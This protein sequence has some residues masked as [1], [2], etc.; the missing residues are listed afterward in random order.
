MASALKTVFEVLLEEPFLFIEKNGTRFI[1]SRDVDLFLLD[2]SCYALKIAKDHGCVIPEN[3]NVEGL[4]VRNPSAD[5]FKN[6]VIASII[7]YSRSLHFMNEEY[8]SALLRKRFW[9]D[10]TRPVCYKDGSWGMVETKAT[11]TY[12]ALSWPCFSIKLEKDSFEKWFDLLLVNDFDLVCLSNQS[13]RTKFARLPSIKESGIDVNLLIQASSELKKLKA[14][15]SHSERLK[16]ET[17]GLYK[18]IKDDALID[19]L[20]DCDKIRAD[21]DSYDVKMITDPNRGHWELWENSDNQINFVSRNPLKDI[22]ENGVVGIDFGTKSTIVVYQNDNECII[23]MRVGTGELKKAVSKEDFENP[24]VMELISLDSFMQ[25][26]ENGWRPKTKWQDLKV[27]R[28]ADKDYFNCSLKNGEYSAFFSDIKQWAGSS[29]RETRNLRDK[30]GKLVTLKPY[31]S[32]EE[33]DF[34]PVEIYAY[35]LGLYINNMRNG[36]F[37]EYYL[38]F[39][40]TYEIDIQT[41]IVKSFERGLKKSLPPAVINDETAMSRFCVNGNVNEPAAYAVCALQE[42]NFIPENF[43]KKIYYGIFDFGGGTTDFDFGEWS[44]SSKKKYDYKITHF[45]AQGDKYLGGE[46]LLELLAFNIFKKNASYLQENDFTFTLPAQCQRFSGS[47]MLIADSSEARYNTKSLM[48]ALRPVWENPDSSEK[49]QEFDESGCLMVTLL[50]SDGSVDTVPLNSSRAEIDKIL[51]K[52][53]QSGIDQFFNAFEAAFHNHG[54]KSMNMEKLYILL[55]GNSSK[56]SLVNELFTKKISEYEESIGVKDLFVLLP[57][58]GSEQFWEE[59]KKINPEF[60]RAD[61]ERLE[62]EIPT[63]KTGVAFGL[64]MARNGGRIEI[65]NQNILG[66]EIP[67][68]F[69]LGYQS[70]GKFQVINDPAEKMKNVGKIDLGTWYEF[71]EVEKGDDVVEVFYTDLPQALHNTMPIAKAQKVRCSFEKAEHDGLFF[72]RA[73]DPH[74]FEYAVVAGRSELKNAKAYTK[75]F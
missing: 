71:Y 70:R 65:V 1:Y 47:E 72:I 26:Y 45:G 37:L 9:T 16:N 59:K 41:R 69:Y 20:L 10:M 51:R 58:I 60:D 19:D 35:Y 21:I 25:A 34:D 29:K 38:S 64:I 22:C 17:S 28:Q 66:D 68:K 73:V 55:A 4:R 39:P 63:G 62:Y 53:I 15:W 30:S 14:Y 32:L 31:T 12:P 61:D 6:G 40:V 54:D 5:I 2:V 43:D 8:F 48:E 75:K 27:S 18:K 11:N 56:S 24:T 23:P 33:E 52:R 46:N 44:L 50:H 42:Y 7:E 3:M 57:P 13:L 67:F 74:T 36:I 49:A